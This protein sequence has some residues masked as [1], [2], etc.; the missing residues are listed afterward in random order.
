GRGA[1]GTDR[2][3]RHPMHRRR[4]R[5]DRRRPCP[6]L[7]LHRGSAPSLRARAGEREAGGAQAGAAG[8]AAWR[9]T[10]VARGACAAVLALAAGTV[11]AQA[12]LVPQASDV[13]VRLRGISAVDADVAWA[14]GREGTVLRTVDGGAHW[15]A[16]RVPGAEAL[17]FRDVEGF[18]ADTAVVLSIGP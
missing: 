11:A 8:R 6:R 18:D 16:M 5:P 4:Q 15:Q 2:R 1:P 14:S 7:P 10:R 12:R 13:D 9:A 17:D 3:G